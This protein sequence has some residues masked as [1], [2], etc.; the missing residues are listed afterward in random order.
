MYIISQKNYNHLFAT[1]HMWK[2]EKNKENNLPAKMHV[3]L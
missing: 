2:A 1:K 3:R